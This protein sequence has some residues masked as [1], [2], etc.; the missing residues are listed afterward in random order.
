MDI[1][2]NKYLVDFGMAQAILHFQSET[3]LGFTIIEKEGTTVA[4]QGDS[5]DS[6][7]RIAPAI[8]HG[9]LER[10]KRHYGYAGA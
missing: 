6:T 4:R 3:S 5:D 2:G 9:Y 10:A 1:I 7:Y 8:I